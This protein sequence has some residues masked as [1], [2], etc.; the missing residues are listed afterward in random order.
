MHQYRVPAELGK[1]DA[2]VMVPISG[3]LKSHS[4]CVSGVKVGAVV[5]DPVGAVGAWVGAAVGAAVGVLDAQ[6]VKVGRVPLEPAF[7]EMV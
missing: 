5:G 2:V 7:H 4:N 3:P 6:N 1:V